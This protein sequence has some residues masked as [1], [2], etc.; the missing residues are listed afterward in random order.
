MFNAEYDSRG[1]AT[2]FD[3]AW[4]MVNPISEHLRKRLEDKGL[5]PELYADFVA[6]KKL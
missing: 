1:M 3:Y 5:N 2:K 6:K 4:E